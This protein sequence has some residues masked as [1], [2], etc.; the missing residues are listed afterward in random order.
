MIYFMMSFSVGFLGVKKELGTG[1]FFM[2][3][4]IFC[5]MDGRVRDDWVHNLKSGRLSI[6][7]Q[8]SHIVVCL[9]VSISESLMVILYLYVAVP[10]YSLTDERL[11][12]TVRD[13]N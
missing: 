2:G 13:R 10:T 11:L 5:C 1:A 4:G 12:K 8:S 9:P 3:L 7:V 6:N